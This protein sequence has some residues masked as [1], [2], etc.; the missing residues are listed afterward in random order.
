[1]ACVTYPTNRSPEPKQW[2]YAGDRYF[3]TKN[4]EVITANGL[5]FNKQ[6]GNYS[7]VYSGHHAWNIKELVS[8]L[9]RNWTPQTFLSE[10]KKFIGADYFTIGNGSSVTIEYDWH[11]QK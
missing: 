10:F 11:L 7:I 4:K 3:V 8:M 1:M 5:D 9:L 2:Q 6:T